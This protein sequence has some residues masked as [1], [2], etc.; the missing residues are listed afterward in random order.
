[1]LESSLFLLG[2]K[3]F[4]F[5]TLIVKKC[6]DPLLEIQLPEIVPVCLSEAVLDLNMELMPSQ[7]LKHELLRDCY[8]LAPIVKAIQSL[9]LCHRLIE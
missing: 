8:L 9:M 6:A 5:K 3:L 4:V 1:M 7:A 2:F